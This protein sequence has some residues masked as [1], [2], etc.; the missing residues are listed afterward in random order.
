M[1]S[2]DNGWQCKIKYVVLDSYILQCIY[3]Y[4]NYGV[5]S[6]S[7][8]DNIIGLFCTGKRDLLKRLYSAK[9][10][11]NFIDPANRSHPILST[12]TPSQQSPAPSHNMFWWRRWPLQPVRAY[13]DLNDIHTHAHAHTQTRPL[14]HPKSV[15][16]SSR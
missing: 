3:L 7:R 1:A 8:F 2:H 15:H 10:T 6:V 13:R 12:R 11:Y 5:A 9:E 4:L 16:V 14:G